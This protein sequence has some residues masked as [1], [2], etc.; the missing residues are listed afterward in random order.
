[1]DGLQS[2][3]DAI[4]LELRLR[5]EYLGSKVV[6]S[7]YLGG[8]TPSL[9]S[10]TQLIAIFDAVT[11]EFEL[12][13]GAEVTLEANPDDLTQE[14]LKYLQDSPVNRLSI[15]VQSFHEADLLFMRRAH[16]AK[17]A[18]ACIEHALKAGFTSLTIDLIYGTP[19]LSNTS[20]KSNLDVIRGFGINHLSCY[21]LTVEAKTLLADRI[22]KKQLSP[23]DDQLAET[24][25]RTLMDFAMENGFLHYEISNYARPG[26][27][28][29]H[30]SSYWKQSPYLG[31]GPSAHSFNG[32]TRS[33]NVSNN[34]HYMKGINEG[35]WPAET[36]VLSLSDRHNEYV[37]TSLR[38]MWGC[39][40]AKVEE[41]NAQP[42]TLFLKG[43]QVFIDRG[44]V[45][46]ED[47]IFYLTQ[48]GKLF[49]D[50]IASE[51]FVV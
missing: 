39:E 31:L 24:H 2:M 29:V 33:W 17:E 48:D 43:V 27:L 40:L 16:N 34:T 15:G 1:M 21:A 36:E 10:S 49:A 11:D 13:P 47:D 23:L 9:L 42:T 45:Y 14:K 41:I 22:G 35:V 51:L 28:A 37:M 8:G 46:S 18:R 25:F 26:H 32:E 3:V 12:S 20:W 50:H 7:I 38:T 19:G 30:N 5:S 4:I 6:D 44:W